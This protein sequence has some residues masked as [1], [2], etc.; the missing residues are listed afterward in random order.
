[1]TEYLKL[2]YFRKY[3]KGIS[4]S[5]GGWKVQDQMATS[6]EG[7]CAD[8]DSLQGESAQEITS[9]SGWSWMR[10]SISPWM[11]SN[12]YEG[13]VPMAQS[14]PGSPVSQ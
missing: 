11:N 5:Y 10:E 6:D 8:G 9:W 3:R 14:P 13:T 1:M 4:H 2:G 7:L 12:I